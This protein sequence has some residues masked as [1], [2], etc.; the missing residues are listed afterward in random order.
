MLSAARR[1]ALAP[2]A[3][4]TRHDLEDPLLLGGVVPGEAAAALARE[5]LESDWNVTTAREAADQL[6]YTAETG[7]REELRAALA[8]KGPRADQ[9]LAR[10]LAPAL[11]ERA[12]L[13]WDLA[14]VP[15]LAGQAYLAGLVT[16]AAAWRACFAAARVVQRTFTGWEP[17]GVELLAGRHYWSGEESTAHFHVFR[18]LVLEREGPWRIAWDTPLDD[19]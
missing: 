12:T 1:W 11:G 13:A 10:K 2:A 8:G 16:E 17:F 3:I 6:V 15:Y 4:E 9:K 5:M 19:A 14:C 18:A 7:T